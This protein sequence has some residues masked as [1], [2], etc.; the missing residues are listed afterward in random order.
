MKIL[1]VCPR[2]FPYIGGVERVVKNVAEHLVSGSHEVTVYST[3]PSKKLPQLQVINGVKVRNY[4]TLAPNEAFYFPHPKMFLHLLSEHADIMHAHSVH[5]LTILVAYTAHNLNAESKFVVSPYYHGKGHTKLAQILWMPYRPVVGRILK[6]ADAIIVNSRVL[7]YVIDRTFKPSCRIFVVYDGANLNEIKNAR[8]FTFDENCR[9][10]LYVGRL[11]K[12][13]NVHI[14]ITSMKYLP[15]NYHFY[16]IGCGPFKPFLENLAQ[17]LHL[18]SRVHFL[19]FKPDDVVYQWLKTAHIFVHLSAVESFGM[20]CIESLA[21]G[22]PVI[23]N[24]DGFGLSETVALFPEHIRIFK[25]GKESVSELARQIME[26]AELKP[27]AAD[28]LRF[29]WDSIAESVRTVY[30]QVLMER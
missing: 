13:K 3:D 10:L 4:S 6:D 5:A 16:I 27:V 22:T 25:V 9:I 12:Y 7:K 14:T 15:E 21:A 11:E 24:D 29:S 19:G 18:R 26:V 28:V 8:S 20:T 2:Y 17:S 23:A 30:K 1:Q